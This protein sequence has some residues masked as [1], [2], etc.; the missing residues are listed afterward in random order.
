MKNIKGY[1]FEKSQELRKIF[2]LSDIS[3]SYCIIR[4]K[5]HH[6]ICGN[7]VRLTN[8]SL[9]RILKYW[10]QG[11]DH[12]NNFLHTTNGVSQG[13][14][15]F[16]IK[17]MQNSQFDTNYDRN[18]TQFLPWPNIKGTN[19]VNGQGIMTITS[20]SWRKSAQPWSQ[21]LWSDGY[22]RLLLPIAHCHWFCA[23]EHQ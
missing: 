17:Y 4:V 11:W 18:L 5:D 1:F 10:M 19:A 12:K 9:S 20:S 22:A 21:Q 7:Q 16:H 15:S 13:S 14:L 3:F 6:P 2:K 8:T 23:N